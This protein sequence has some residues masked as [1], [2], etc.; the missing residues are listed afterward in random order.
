MAFQFITRDMLPPMQMPGC[1]EPSVCISISGSVRFNFAAMEAF[2]LKA[3]DYVDVAWDQG[4]RMVAFK[5]HHGKTPNGY[6]LGTSAGGC[7]F[8]SKRLLRLMGLADQPTR[9]YPLAM[10]DV[11]RLVVADLNK[12][13]PVR[14]ANKVGKS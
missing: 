3:G 11:A 5:P 8:T 6:A 12:P 9:R 13:I 7:G 14:G 4:R 1:N 10:D 2:A